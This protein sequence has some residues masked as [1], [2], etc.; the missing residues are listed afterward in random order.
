MPVAAQLVDLLRAL[1]GKA[2]A[3]A[4]IKRAMAW[5]GGF[6]VQEAGPDGVVRSFGSAGPAHRP[7][8]VTRR[9][10]GYACS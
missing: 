9:A 7:M 1:N 10:W 8:V 3:D 2:S 6:W 4:Q 5:Q